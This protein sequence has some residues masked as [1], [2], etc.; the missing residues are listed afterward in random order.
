M[1]V[2]I[3]PISDL[4]PIGLPALRGNGDLDGMP[5]LQKG[6]R[7]SVQPVSV[8]HFRIICK[9]GNLAEIPT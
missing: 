7:L 1:M 5:L 8:E 2:D 9:M 4:E 6:Q 3:E